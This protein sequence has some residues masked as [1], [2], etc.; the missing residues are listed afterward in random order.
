MIRRPDGDGV[1]DFAFLQRKGGLFE[2]RRI[3]CRRPTERRQL[4]TETRSARV[5]TERPRNIFKFL[6]RR[7]PSFGLGDLLEIRA[8]DVPDLHLF[9][10]EGIERLLKLL[11]AD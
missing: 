7:E 9:T 2:I 1:G 4:A 6:S 10:I 5:A 3:S 11:I 8:F